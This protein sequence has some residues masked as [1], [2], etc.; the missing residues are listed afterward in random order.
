M[1]LL[2]YDSSANLEIGVDLEKVHAPS[3]RLPD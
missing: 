1:L 3:N 2:L